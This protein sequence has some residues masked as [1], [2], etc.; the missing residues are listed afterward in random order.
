MLCQ[1]TDAVGLLRKRNLHPRRAKFQRV[2]GVSDI[3]YP[4][5]DLRTCFGGLATALLEINF[6]GLSLRASSRLSKGE[7]EGVAQGAAV[8]LYRV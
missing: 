4:E 2:T 3:A 1:L 6:P 8:R 5:D 7:R